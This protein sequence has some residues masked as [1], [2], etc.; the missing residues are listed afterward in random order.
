VLAPGEAPQ[1]RDESKAPAPQQHP[2][3]FRKRHGQ[4]PLQF[5]SAQSL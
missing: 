4:N 2:D 5:I 3:P 1:A